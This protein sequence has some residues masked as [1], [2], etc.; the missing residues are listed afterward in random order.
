MLKGLVL[1]AYAPVNV[2]RK[3]GKRGGGG[4]EGGLVE[5]LNQLRFSSQMSHYK[6][7][8]DDQK[9]KNVTKLKQLIESLLNWSRV[10]ITDRQPPP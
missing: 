2:S 6:A 10:P 8:V 7:F 3:E 5:Q 4:L 1:N 9:I